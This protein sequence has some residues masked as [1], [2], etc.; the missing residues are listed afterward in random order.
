M[1][2]HQPSDTLS[3]VGEGGDGGASVA[4]TVTPIGTIVAPPSTK[5][6]SAAISASVVFVVP[7]G[8]T[9]VDGMK[10]IRLPLSA[11]RSSTDRQS[12]GVCR[13]GAEVSGS[14]RSTATTTLRMSDRS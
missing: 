5:Y 10:P 9:H 8:S 7:N 2:S 1:Y 6:W 11:W 13:P 4:P 14:A 12:A 3:V